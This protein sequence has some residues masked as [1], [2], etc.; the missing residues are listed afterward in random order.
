MGS[1]EKTFAS[2]DLTNGQTNALVKI[3]GGADVV[4]GILA[5]TVEVITK[6]VEKVVEVV[7]NVLEHAGEILLASVPSFNPQKYFKTRKGRLYVW[8]D[9][10][11]RILAVAEPTGV[12]ELQLD[13]YALKQ[14]A[15]DSEMGL[16]DDDIFEASEFCAYLAQMID[17]QS[18]GQEGTLLTN[19]HANIFRVR[20]ADGEVFTVYVS[21][22]SDH[23]L[24]RVYAYRL[25]DF[26]WPAG[27]R[28]FRK[29][30]V[31]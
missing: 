21:R 24:W 6:P 15:Y 14:N 26:P 23:R 19:G 9:F 12:P 16:T 10:V 1:D 4:L 22:H 17:K 27:R 7:T 20:G 18:R 5:G 11:R 31:A 29:T 8:D 28:V 13:Y 25:D 30:A 2:A 3:L